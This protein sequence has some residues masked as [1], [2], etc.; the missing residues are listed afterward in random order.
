MATIKITVDDK[1]Y[2]LAFNKKTIMQM[3][4]NGFRIEKAREDYVSG[5]PQLFAGSFLRFHR[6]ITEKE[7]D[8]IWNMIPDK[9]GFIEALIGL[10][11]E[12]IE[13]IFGEPE[14]DEKKASW[15][16]VKS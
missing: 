8:A 9:L 1:E 13:Q 10:Y 11:N 7:I 5:I 2:T 6:T 14:D 16:V 3:S 15:E 12:Q 4:D